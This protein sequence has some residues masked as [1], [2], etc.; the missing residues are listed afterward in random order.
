[1]DLRTTSLFRDSRVRMQREKAR[2]TRA[3]IF[4]C[5]S[6]TRYP[7]CLRA[8]NWLSIQGDGDLMLAVSS[9]I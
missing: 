1:M 4:G 3:D 9:N 5:L 6:L 7:S 8:W 2:T